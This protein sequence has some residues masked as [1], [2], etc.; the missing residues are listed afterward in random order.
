[1]R[2]GTFHE[3]EDEEV[4]NRFTEEGNLVNPGEKIM[5]GIDNKKFICSRKLETTNVEAYCYEL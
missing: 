4:L 5:D 1:M 2:N 3:C